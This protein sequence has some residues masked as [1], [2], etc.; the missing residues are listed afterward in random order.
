MIIT[1]KHQSINQSINQS[2]SQSVTN[3]VEQVLVAAERLTP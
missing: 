2:I 3:E 1:I